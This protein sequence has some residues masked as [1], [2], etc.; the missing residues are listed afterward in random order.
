MKQTIKMMVRAL[1]LIA[2][3]CPFKL[4][5]QVPDT[6]TVQKLIQYIFQPV[7]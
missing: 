5:A 3:V 6:S 4:F 1:Y 7:N 2:I